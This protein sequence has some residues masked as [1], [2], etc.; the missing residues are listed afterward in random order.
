MRG[1]AQRVADMLE[2]AE[3][4]EQQ[5]SKGRERFDQHEIVQLALVHLV[6]IIGEA[7]SRIS[8]IS[9]SAIRKSRGGWVVA[10][11]DY[12]LR[13]RVGTPAGQRLP[14]DIRRES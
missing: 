2:A 7:A 4:L 1:D 12:L 10:E 14:E 13:H 6:R 9:G 3:K 5:A 11:L 8:D